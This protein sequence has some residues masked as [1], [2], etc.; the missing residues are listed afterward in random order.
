MFSDKI[1]NQIHNITGIRIETQ[2]LRLV[3]NVIP[4]IKLKAKE[5]KV[6]NKDNTTALALIDTKVNIRILPL[7]SGKVHINSFETKNIEANLILNDKL[8]LGDYPIEMQPAEMNA[9]ID[10]IK[11]EKIDLN[12]AENNETNKISGQNIYFKTTKHRF[13]THGKI[14]CI[15]KQTKSSCDFD[16]QL[17]KDKKLQ[18]TRF[19][20]SA[21][22]FDIGM[23]SGI[24]SKCLFN[25]IKKIEGK[26]NIESDT[27]HL[28]ADL[29]NIKVLCQD[30]SNSI[31]FP[32]T[33]NICSDYKI[34]Q[35]AFHIKEC[36]VTG[37]GINSSLSGE[38]NNIFSKTPEFDLKTSIK[39]TDI[40]KGALILP[41]IITED[42]NIKKLKQYPFYG[43][44]SGDMKI[45]GKFP[46]PDITGGLRVTEG[47]LINP[48][49]NT[50]QGADIAINFAGQKLLLDVVVQA[51]KNEVVYVTGDIAIYGEK[52]VHLRI[53][54]SKSVNLNVAE[55]VLN[56]L[57][58]ILC[59]LIGPVPIMDVEGY[60]NIDIKVVGTKK[61]PHIWGDFNFVNT[62][63]RF[64]EVNNLT[65]Q[66]ATGNLNFNNQNAHF[67][68][69][70]GTLHGQPMKIDGVCTLFGD[71]D[72]NV[73]AK[74][75]ELNNLII[76][77]TT[78][79][80]L[81]DMKSLVPPMKNIK[82]KSDFILSL[83]GKVKDVDDIK[84]N[85]T[86]FPKGYIKLLGNSLTLHG[87][88]L[89]N[90]KG[91]I[92]FEKAD[93]DFNLNGLISSASK[94]VFTGKIKNGISEITI[95][96][97]KICVN[98]LEPDKLKWLDKLY[99][100]LNAKYK[101]K[102]DTIEIG[103]IDSTIEV[104][105]DNKPVKNG[106]ITSG[107]ITLRNSN[108]T[109]NNISGF[110]QNN[111]FKLNLT[112]R[113]IGKTNV[114]LTKAKFNGEFNCKDFDLTSVNYIR[115]AKILPSA[116]Q[117]EL[118][119]INVISGNANVNTKVVNNK[120]NSVL[121]MNSINFEYSIQEGP[122]KELVTIPIKMINGQLILR[123]NIVRLNKF[124]C[125]ID[126]MP[127]LLFGHIN[128]I[129]KN[130]EFNLHINSKLIQR[131]FDKYWNAHNIYPIKMHGDI[132][133]SSHII[134][135]KNHT[136]LKSDI[137]MEENSNIYYM[138]ATIGDSLNP[139]TVNVDA[140]IDKNGKIKLNNFNYNKLISSQNNRSNIL[141]L[142]S[143]K[144][145]IKKQGKIYAFKNLIVKTE[146]PA[147]ANFFNIIFKKP[148]IKHGNFTSDLKIN[149]T[150]NNPKI[151]GQFNV[152]NM[153]MPY[154]NTTIKDLD[155]DFN[156]DNI[157]ITT[158]GEV[159]ANY[160]MFN[161][162]LKNKLVPPYIIN[163]ANIYINDFD[164]NHSINQLKQME[165]KGLSSAISPDTDAAGNDL[166]NSVIFKDVKIRAGN[167]RIK[168]IK[169][170]NL[171]A[172]CS[173]DEKMHLGVNSFKFNMASGIISGKLNYNLLNNFMKMEL[174]SKAVNAN[175]LTIALFDLPNQIYGSLTGR[176]ELSCNATND[177]TRMETLNGFGQFNVTN[178]RMPKLGSLEYLLKAG[179]LIKGG[180][181]SL[182]MNGII[183][184]ITPMKTGEF[185][186][187]S[188]HFKIKDGIAETLEINSHG[189]DLNIYIT[190]KFNFATQ[191]ADMNVFG[192][193]SRKISTVLGA[194]GNISL[195]T[196]F[197]KIPGISL[198]SNNQFITDLNKI[199]GI[200]FSNKSSRKFMVEILGDINGEDFVKSFRWIN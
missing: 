22:N 51:G 189:K 23:F 10:R 182:S 185:S 136:H 92:N 110:V 144:G 142:L 198:D 113:N 171:E 133:Y 179:N 127:I 176:I 48:I 124:N 49:P 166:L 107:K 67:V 145:E 24:A 79:P 68:N 200:E 16:I 178:G 28:S 46:N 164:V 114:D 32:N 42:F 52:F 65:L 137:R 143:I 71:L 158:R 81:T 91:L 61:D 29:N 126:N 31:I 87:L 94:A 130:P 15:E 119:K 6:L 135:D 128:N 146:N 86:I 129:Y 186:S 147:N 88:N 20:I 123:N 34:L 74:N 30:N 172:I 9:L 181:T 78:S 150:S 151:I 192:Q 180:I 183:D 109:I 19:N 38:I 55:H 190:G 157:V 115:K 73:I 139:I 83:K 84:I 44:I 59:F 43:K 177:K 155:L 175:A 197:N 106:K 62:S 41:S 54:S 160:I 4:H 169:A 125:L 101:G 159:L 25:D 53:R 195:N 167:V 85:E 82:G 95:N 153:E 3:T 196:L 168:N 2:G 47:V 191:I 187:I 45:K 121:D 117:N 140:D 72:F 90:V 58:E 170:S 102:I 64:L 138:G 194:A 70:T 163:G 50:T 13:I 7:L 131:V 165:L 12:I 37:D 63:A 199:P 93:C 35:N 57:H 75:Q 39:D 66:N 100:K 80:M 27:N 26:I 112:A 96:A 134:G 33:L 21:N 14:E 8:Y 154:L 5:L 188:G 56:P 162:K 122:K 118:D 116:L 11:L 105:K 156:P 108:L 103:G 174:D 173:L 60:G 152:T 149:G 17:P 97:P 98:E 104:L 120:L 69:N 99:I 18:K 40:R 184:I 132:L 77:L 148:T 141:P 76:T 193:I 89:T 36:K 161:A 111:P 1:L